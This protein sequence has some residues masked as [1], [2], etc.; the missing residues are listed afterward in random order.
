MFLLHRESLHLDF[1]RI[2]TICKRIPSAWQV[3][4]RAEVREK[5]FLPFPDEERQ[6]CIGQIVAHERC[7]PFV[8]LH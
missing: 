3:G 7:Y 4:T 1:A 6:I 8:L 2:F 5:S